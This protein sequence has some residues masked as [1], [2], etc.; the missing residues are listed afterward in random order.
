MAVKMGAEKRAR[1]KYFLAEKWRQT[2][3]RRQLTPRPSDSILRQ[4]ETIKNEA[5]RI[6]PRCEGFH[7]IRGQFCVPSL[8]DG[9]VLIVDARWPRAWLQAGRICRGQ[10]HQAGAEPTRRLRLL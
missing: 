3:G 5:R 10:S 1:R 4:Y 7:E 6:K 9:S 8:A 2:G